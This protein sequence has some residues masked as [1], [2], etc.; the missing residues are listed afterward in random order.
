MK[1]STSSSGMEFGT[2]NPAI[3]E[4]INQYENMTKDRYA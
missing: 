2:I 1:D 3:E 4:I